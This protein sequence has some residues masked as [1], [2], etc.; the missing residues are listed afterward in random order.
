MIA[1]TSVL[2]ML[3]GLAAPERAA[4]SPAVG[5]TNMETNGSPY[6]HTYGASLAGTTPLP[7]MGNFGSAGQ[8]ANQTDSGKNFSNTNI[9]NNN[10][11]FGNYD[12]SNTF[13][14]AHYVLTGF[15]EWPQYESGSPK[16]PNQ[17]NMIAGF[18]LNSVRNDNS[19]PGDTNDDFFTDQNFAF[20]TADAL[21]TH[22]PSTTNG[23]TMNLYIVRDSN[24]GGSLLNSANPHFSPYDGTLPWG[25]P[26][27]GPVTRRTNIQFS[28]DVF[29]GGR[30]S[31]AFGD[32]YTVTAEPDVTVSTNDITLMAG[33][34]YQ[35]LSVGNTGPRSHSKSILTAIACIYDDSNGVFSVENHLGESWTNGIGAEILPITNGEVRANAVVIRAPKVW[36]RAAAKLDLYFNDPETNQTVQTINLIAL[37]AQ[38]T[39]IL[40]R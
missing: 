39:V 27:G 24:L 1:G 7:G 17:V 2:A 23:L 8:Y 5:F 37:P 33:H 26:A 16:W 6:R 29:Q 3:V 38:G 32:F 40:I 35:N 14:D 31:G 34:L 15:G 12:G 30:H 28:W 19:T 9:L 10:D 4:A 25:S 21:D 20:L 11:A 18:R 22:I 13:P 36:Q